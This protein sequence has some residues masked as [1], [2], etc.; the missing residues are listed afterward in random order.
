MPPSNALEEV[1]V[2][3]L[4]ESFSAMMDAAISGARTSSVDESNIGRAV[5]DAAILLYRYA[6]PETSEEPS[7]IGQ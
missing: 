5:L 2:L 3:D 7:I 1:R 4:I 6:D